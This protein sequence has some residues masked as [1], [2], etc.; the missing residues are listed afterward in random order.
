MTGS[1]DPGKF[2]SRLMHKVEIQEPDG[3][4]GFATQWRDRCSLWALVRPLA[5]STGDRAGNHVASI[6]HEIVIRA[7]DHV[8]PGSRFMSGSRTFDIDAVY[9]PD[10]SGRY[11]VCRATER[12]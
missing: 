8:V 3:C 10:E 12:N 6:A 5:A 9:D 2:R 7:N 11:L 4:G 1:I